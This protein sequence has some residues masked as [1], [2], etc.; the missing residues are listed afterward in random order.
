M[1][2]GDVK[3]KVPPKGEGNVGLE[4]T[5]GD[6]KFPGSTKEDLVGDN[7]AHPRGGMPVV[8]VCVRSTTKV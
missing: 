8:D 6:T 4:N 2:D 1:C 3:A 7:W 5:L